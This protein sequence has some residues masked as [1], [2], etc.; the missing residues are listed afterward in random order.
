MT[1]YNGTPGDDSLTGGGTDDILNGFDGNDTL[2]GGKGNDTLVGGA[3]NDS[4]SGGGVTTVVYSGNFADYVI[5]HDSNSNVYTVSDTV[6]GRD[7]TDSVFGAT[8][9][10]FADVT[11]PYSLLFGDSLSGG[12]GDDVLTGGAGNDTLYGGKGNDTLTGGGGDDFLSGGNGT[13]TAVLSG[14][15]ADYV[16]THNA[17]TDIYTIADTVLHRDG[18]DQVTGVDFFQFADGTKLAPDAIGTVTITGTSGNDVL[19][20]D[21]G[22]EIINGQ[23]GNDTLDGGDGAVD[24][25]L[26]SGNF[27]DYLVSYD[28]GSYQYVIADSVGGRDGTDR[29]TDVEFFQ[30]ADGTKSAAQLIGSNLDGTDANDSLT[31]GPGNDSL[32]GGKGNDTLTGGAGNDVLHGGDGTDT[33][34]FSGYHAD[35]TLSYDGST[36]TYSIADSVGGRDGADSLTGIEVLQFADGSASPAELMGGVFYGSAG[37]D[38]ISGGIGTDTLYG[39][40]GDDTLTGG[41][42]DDS[43]DGGSGTDTAVLSGNFADYVITYDA[44]TGVFT[45]ADS[46]VGRDGTDHILNVELI[47]FAD[48]AKAIGD[49]LPAVTI[50][51]TSGNDVLI[52]DIGRD[53]LNG[54]GGN[55]TLNGGG[56]TDTAVFSGNFADYLISYDGGSHTFFIADSAGGRDGTDGVTNVE[57][58]QFADGTKPVGQLIG[59]NLDSGDTSDSVTGGPGNDSLYG[60]KGNDTLTGGAGNDALHGGDGTDTAVYSGNV[61]DYAISYNAGAGSGTAF[62]TIADTV[63]GRDGTDH[64]TEME[65]F[66]F[67]DGTL[68][69]SQLLLLQGTA[70]NDSLT[71]TNAADLLFGYAGNDSLHGGKGD[72]V[73]NGGAGNDLLDGGDGNDTASY[74]GT[75]AAVIVSLASAAAQNTGG[76][77]TDTLTSIENLI[78]GAGNDT[79]TGNAVANRLE[80]GAGNDALNGGAGA[81][82]MLGGVGNDAYVVDNAGDV[83][84]ENVGEGTD[85]VTSTVS[86]ALPANVENLTLA[87][88]S[89]I[90]GSGNELNN[91]LTGNAAANTLTGNDGNDV[92]HGAAGNDVLDGG[93]GNDVLDGGLGS[94]HLSGGDG[95]DVYFVDVSTDVITEGASQGIDTVTSSLSYALGA[96]VENLILLA[97]SKALIG[98]GNSLD[99]VITGNASANTLIGGE[100][101]DTLAGGLGGDTLTGGAGNDVFVFNTSPVKNIDKITDFNAANDAIALDHHIFA[102]LGVGSLPPSSFQAGASS[103]AAGAGVHIIFNTAT[104]GLFYDADGAGGVAAVQFATIVLAGLAGPVTAADFIVT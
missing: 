56:G 15:F 38:S 28:G 100:G 25:A 21:I 58:F 62:Y 85:T 8:Y 77:G 35:Y 2:Y 64:V 16:I 31:G 94:D 102:A 59:S 19:I 12:S 103:T 49:T 96:N 24:T 74:A 17:S 30:F 14:N 86:Y 91:V 20:G 72:D 18:T 71:G 104:G 63:A 27:A 39:G 11:K 9:Y 93:A 44:A 40:K 32:Y 51:G 26:L 80:G 65:Y 66:R 47:Q 68:A 43:L 6:A 70:G 52:G 5:T 81:D 57:L 76:A 41:M 60:G 97:G 69:A 83:V 10:K 45:V 54:L 22:A 34:R 36:D 29:V 48:G 101:N 78:G 84:T 90:N 87:G 73:L 1:T 23:G 82:T 99:N 61:A 67:A 4:L 7:D 42:G 3:G 55:D 50:T 33:A 88:T 95:D 46:V 37:S 92:L 98:T 53:I 89:A 75:S 13:D 79:L